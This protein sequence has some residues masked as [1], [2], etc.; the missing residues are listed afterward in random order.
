MGVNL[1]ML[2][3]LFGERAYIGGS[4]CS[5]TPRVGMCSLSA[6]DR[7]YSA[8]FV[9]QCILLKPRLLVPNIA[10][11]ACTHRFNL[12]TCLSKGNP[13]GDIRQSWPNPKKPTAIPEG[14]TGLL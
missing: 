2:E 13:Q 10:Y 8:P 11:N 14:T 5:E 1:P 3:L 6:N 9:R 12:F 4:A 7:K